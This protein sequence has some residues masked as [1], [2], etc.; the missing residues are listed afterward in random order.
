MGIVEWL[1][2]VLTTVVCA[3]LLVELNDYLLRKEDERKRS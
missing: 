2:V 1:V 3:I